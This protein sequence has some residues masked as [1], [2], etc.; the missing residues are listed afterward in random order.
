MIA[1]FLGTIDLF[2]VMM[3]FTM[4]FMPHKIMMFFAMLLFAKGM[5][6]VFSGD[7]MSIMDTAGGLY[8]GLTVYG[9]SHIALTI[10]FII[11]FHNIYC[12]GE[13]YF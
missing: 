6:F 11:F 7:W 10:L 9:F 5:I 8:I 3:L 12:I 1:K 4:K 13:K 2:C